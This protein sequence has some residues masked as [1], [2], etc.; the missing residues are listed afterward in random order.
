M[1]EIL[2]NKRRIEKKIAKI[3]EQI[4]IAQKNREI[5]DEKCLWEELA[6]LQKD[7]ENIEDELNPP[8]KR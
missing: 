3:G 5:H 8:W 6:P 2:H 7:L 1:K 4:E